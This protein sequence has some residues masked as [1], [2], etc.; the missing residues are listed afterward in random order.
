MKHQKYFGF[1]RK[2]P[3]VDL[4]SKYP[5]W[6]E[7]SFLAVLI[8]MCVMFWSFQRY[9]PQV[10]LATI[11]D[12][13]I[14]TEVVPITEHPKERLKPEKP[15]IPVSSEEDEDLPVDIDPDEIFEEW[16]LGI[17]DVPPPIEEPEP[18]VAPFHGLSEKPQVIHQV[19][20]LYPELAQKADVEGTVV[21]EVLINT[22]GMVEATKILK[23]HDLF[24]SAAVT[25]AK[26]F[27]FTPAKQRDR[28]VKVWVSIPFKFRLN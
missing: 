2:H 19:D 9:Q 11:S 3:A 28:L 14:I 18:I 16:K 12:N 4:H 25:A 22:K 13:T 10:T 1:I 27:R 24:D 6:V 21:I 8:G 17:D 23:S 5:R 26:Q 15:K 7:G 20:P